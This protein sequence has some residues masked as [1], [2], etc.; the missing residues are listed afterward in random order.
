MTSQPLPP[1]RPTVAAL[2]SYIAGRRSSSPATAPLASN[3]SHFPPLPAVLEAITATGARA[4]RYPDMF[5]RALTG[6]VAD[7]LGVAADQLAFGP[8]SVGVLAQVIGALCDPGE[9]VIFAWR[10]FEAYPIL[11]TLAGAV[12]VTVPLTA[13]ERHDLPAMVAAITARTKVVL[14][15]SPNNPTGT[16]IS[17]DELIGFLDQV[18]AGVLV[19]L[20]EAYREFGPADALN[21]VSLLPRYPNL[22]LLRTFSK[23][24]G[25][26]GLRVGYAVAHP[27]LADGLRKTQLPF[28]VSAVAEA[29]AV[30]ALGSLEL[31]AQRSAEVVAE[32]ERVIAAVRE[33][34]WTTPDSAANFFWLRAEDQRRSAL[35]DA[36]DAADILVRGY[37]VDGVRITIADATSNDRVLAVLAAHPE[38]RA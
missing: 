32:R 6:R 14:L 1:L 28:S 17:E 24:Y 29:A 26:A 22:C 2:P 18:P 11:C 35:V 13:D 34:G 10:S 5:S 21:P 7:W 27:E 37:P 31:V 8:G 23:A 38:L 33:L 3:E 9:E 25:L 30:A 4:N 16:S 36:F 12:P 19:V 20:D 15:C